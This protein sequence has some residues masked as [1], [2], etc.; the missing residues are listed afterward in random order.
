MANTGY[1]DRICNVRF[2]PTIAAQASV[3]ETNSASAPG[4]FHN[5][6]FCSLIV[7]LL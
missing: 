2:G 1:M 3:L 5:F 7:N 4:G 6:D